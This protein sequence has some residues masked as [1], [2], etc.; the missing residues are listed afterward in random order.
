[1]LLGAVEFLQVEKVG[2]TGFVRVQLLED[3]T[4]ELLSRFVHFALNKKGETPASETATTFQCKR[5]HANKT[6]RHT[7]LRASVIFI[8]NACMETTYT[9]KIS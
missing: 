8:K 9:R 7:L 6:C 5:R 2:V 4:D 1:M 3:F